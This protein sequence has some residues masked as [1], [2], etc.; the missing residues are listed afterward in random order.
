MYVLI[1]IHVL[2]LVATF[3]VI[4]IVLS[5][6]FVK[7]NHS[8]CNIA[9]ISNF[10]ST[11]HICEKYERF[12]CVISM[13]AKIVCQNINY[14]HNNAH[15]NENICPKTT[16][17]KPIDFE[18]GENICYFQVPLKPYIYKQNLIETNSMRTSILNGIFICSVI[19][20]TMTV[21]LMI[22]MMVISVSH[23]KK[24]FF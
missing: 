17:Q 22:S 16:I 21:L 20:L 7:I 9:K 13:H 24:I 15:Y 2:T 3:S 10:E 12:E 6:H 23:A 18:L 14:T 8:L 19:V 5:S 4:G 1:P 11:L